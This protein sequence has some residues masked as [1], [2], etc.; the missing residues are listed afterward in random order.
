[1]DSMGIKATVTEFKEFISIL[2]NKGLIN[3]IT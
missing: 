3:K 1:M 2:E